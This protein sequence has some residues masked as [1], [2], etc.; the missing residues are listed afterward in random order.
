MG[1]GLVLAATAAAAVAG[2][3]Q[4]VDIVS[5]LQEEVEEERRKRQVERTGRI[6]VQQEHKSSQ[7][8]KSGNVHY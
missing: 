8:Q 1:L 2:Y 4:H 5:R 3:R 6:R 7:Q